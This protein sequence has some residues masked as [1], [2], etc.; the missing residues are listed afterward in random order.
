MSWC[1][2]SPR[3]PAARLTALAKVDA[4]LS[5]DVKTAVALYE[6][7]VA[8]YNFLNLALYH[9]QYPNEPKGIS[10]LKLI[11]SYGWS[12]CGGEH[13]VDQD[14]VAAARDSINLR[15]LIRA[16]IPAL[17]RLPRHP[18]LQRARRS[19]PDRRRIRSDD[20]LGT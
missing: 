18:S 14:A 1:E 5:V 2:S 12:L 20:P 3:C 10:A 13:T 15:L 9:F 17:P 6:K 11:N 16:A 8:L 7:A 4:G 19:L